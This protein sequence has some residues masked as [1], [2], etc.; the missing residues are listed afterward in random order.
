MV[1][2]LALYTPEAYEIGL[3]VVTSSLRVALALA[4]EP[5][6]HRRSRTGDCEIRVQTD[7][8]C[9]H[10]MGC[11]GGVPAVRGPALGGIGGQHHLQADVGVGGSDSFNVSK[12]VYIGLAGSAGASASRPWGGGDSGS[13]CVAAAKS[14]QSVVARLGTTFLL[15]RYCCKRLAIEGLA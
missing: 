9:I 4:G 13:G 12:D 3:N 1:S 6:A 5:H 2:T 14:S 10:A 11:G 8:D 7:D 15:L